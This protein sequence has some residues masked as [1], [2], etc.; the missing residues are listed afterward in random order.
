MAREKSEILEK[1]YDTQL[2]AKR[3]RVAD[4]LERIGGLAVDDPADLGTDSRALRT[5]AEARYHA[6]LQTVA[7]AEARSYDAAPKEP[8]CQTS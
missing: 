7:S 3:K 5:K 1:A 6:W 2:E 8:E 4:A